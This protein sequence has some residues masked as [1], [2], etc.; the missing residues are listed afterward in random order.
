MPV[1]AFLPVL[2]EFSASDVALPSKLDT[3]RRA[4]ENA[5]HEPWRASWN[6]S[7]SA[8]AGN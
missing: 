1:I 8:I 2:A 3:L 5:A 6:E 7:R 4:E